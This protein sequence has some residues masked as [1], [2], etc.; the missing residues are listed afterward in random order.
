MSKKPYR[1]AV[2]GG[3]GIGP[4]VT[5]AALDVVRAA[6]VQVET[7][8]YELG[9]AR[10]LKD[11]FVLDDKTL[12]ELRGYDAIMLGA[13]GPAIGDTRI[14]GGVLERGR[15]GPAWPVQQ[16]PPRDVGRREHGGDAH[17]EAREVEPGHLVPHV[18]SGEGARGGPTWS[19]NPPCS[20]LRGDV[21]RG[22]AAQ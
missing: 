10:Y 14:P 3:D 12:E 11:G 21:V 9:A 1:V 20:Y 16:R 15:V 22:P 17:A 4:E 19:K 2:I 8:D 6:G 18:V 13:I 7:T 5:Q